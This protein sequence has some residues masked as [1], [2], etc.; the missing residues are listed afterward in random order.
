MKSKKEPAL[1]QKAIIKGV[2]KVLASIGKLLRD[3]FQVMLWSEDHQRETSWKPN[4]ITLWL[5]KITLLMIRWLEMPLSIP[6]QAMHQACKTH[7]NQTLVTL[8]KAFHMTQHRVQEPTTV[9]PKISQMIGSGRTWAQKRAAPP[10]NDIVT[11]A[12][13]RKL[14]S[15][16][17]SNN[18]TWL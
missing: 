6:S 2:R 1:I 9:D 15:T 16:N 11:W 17:T 12:I 4:K 14:K 5:H 7:S 13:S 8:F 18:S 3:N 10:I